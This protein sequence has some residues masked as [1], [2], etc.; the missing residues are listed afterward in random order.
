MLHLQELVKKR[1]ELDAAEVDLDDD[2]SV[3]I[4]TEKVDKQLCK[5]YGNLQRALGF[6]KI[7]DLKPKFRCSGKKYNS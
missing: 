3:Y 6:S 2:N 5:A 7:D 4:Q 1:E